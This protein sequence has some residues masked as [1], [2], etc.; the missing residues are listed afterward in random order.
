MTVKTQVGFAGLLPGLVVEM[1]FKAPMQKNANPAYPV[2][3]TKQFKSRRVLRKRP[4]NSSSCLQ[5]MKIVH[6]SI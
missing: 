4:A 1:R 3:F 6:F 5:N 2:L